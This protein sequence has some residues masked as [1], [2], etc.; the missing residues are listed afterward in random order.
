MQGE[1]WEVKVQAKHV[2][3]DVIMAALASVRG[4]HGVPQW[5]T[6]WDT[7][8]ALPQFPEKVVLASPC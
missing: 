7:Q 1:V 5:S 4:M 3:D 2:A 8:K 6:L